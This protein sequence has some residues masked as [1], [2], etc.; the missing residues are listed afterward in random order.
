MRL[1]RYGV[2]LLKDLG[3]RNIAELETC[4]PLP[5]LQIFSSGSGLY[6]TVLYLMSG[7]LNLSVCEWQTG[8]QWSL[9]TPSF[10]LSHGTGG[11]KMGEL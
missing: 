3:H 11:T 1:R 8:T 7:G 5:N 2:Q 4:Q 9:G 10:S 6:V